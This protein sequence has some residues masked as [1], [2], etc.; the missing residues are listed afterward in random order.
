[1]YM[2]TL[3]KNEIINDAQKVI[4]YMEFINSFFDSISLKYR[5]NPKLNPNIDKDEIKPTME[6]IVIAIPTSLLV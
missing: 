6:I 2:P 1:M 4:L 3:K 5:I